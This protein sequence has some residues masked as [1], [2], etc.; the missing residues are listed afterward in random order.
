MKRSCG[1]EPVQRWSNGL[2]SELQDFPEQ[3]GFVLKKSERLLDF[4]KGK[5]NGL[6]LSLAVELAISGM[7]CPK[8]LSGP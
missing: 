2:A 1:K 3:A 6:T 5:V 7:V 8:L 4:G